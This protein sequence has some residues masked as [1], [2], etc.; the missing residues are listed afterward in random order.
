MACSKYKSTIF[1]LFFFSVFFPFFPTKHLLV[2]FVFFKIFFL[3]QRD[4]D[5]FSV[6]S[7]ELT[8]NMTFISGPFG[9]TIHEVEENDTGSNNVDMTPKSQA[10]TNLNTPQSKKSVRKGSKPSTPKKTERPKSSGKRD[11]SKEKP[12]NG[13]KAPAA[14]GSS[15]VR[16]EWQWFAHSLFL[17]FLC[18]KRAS[19]EIIL[20]FFPFHRALI[21]REKGRVPHLCNFCTTAVSQQR[22]CKMHER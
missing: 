22:F 18:C 13:K 12:P 7:F 17:A 16:A 15:K 19:I 20:L 6:Y 11:G 10:D 1:F 9:E 4:S 3:I 8:E 5:A 14:N 2:F 21:G